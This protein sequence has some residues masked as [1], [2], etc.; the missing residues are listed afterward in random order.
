MKGKGLTAILSLAIGEE[1]VASLGKQTQWVFNDDTDVAAA[2]EALPINHTATLLEKLAV[3]VPGD[4]LAGLAVLAQK[5]RDGMLEGASVVTAIRVHT[6]VA[7]LFGIMYWLASSHDKDKAFFV[8][9]EKNGAVTSILVNQVVKAAIEEFSAGI[10]DCID[11]A[12][13]DVEADS[14]ADEPDEG[15]KVTTNL[16]GNLKKALEDFTGHAF[17][18]VIEIILLSVIERLR[19]MGAATNALAPNWTYYIDETKYNK[20]LAKRQLCTK[21]CTETLP[22]QTQA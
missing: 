4:L 12:K 17:P 10:S 9:Q 19:A 15:D 21:D 22:L 7:K 8:S 3:C 2:L 5:P 11:E 13:I 16:L 14:D 20:T 6:R 1:A 18:A